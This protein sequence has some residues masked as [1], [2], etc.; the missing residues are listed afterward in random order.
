MEDGRYTAA[1]LI[2]TRSQKAE[3]E[4]EGFMPAGSVDKIERALMQSRR[5]KVILANHDATIFTL[6]GA[7]RGAGQ[8]SVQAGGR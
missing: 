7:P 2:I 5:F 8:R 3:V 4:E 6:A 1:Y